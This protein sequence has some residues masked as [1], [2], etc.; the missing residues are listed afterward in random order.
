M[1]YAVIASYLYTV[2]K[3]Q[4]ASFTST[5]GCE[6]KSNLS[7]LKFSIVISIEKWEIVHGSN[8][9]IKSLSINQIK[10][11][12]MPKPKVFKGSSIRWYEGVGIILFIGYT[13]MYQ[14]IRYI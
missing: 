11:H 12:D 3:K 10:I 9:H 2:Y 5:H 13:L 6:R 8:T 4:T 7:D 1:L 14:L